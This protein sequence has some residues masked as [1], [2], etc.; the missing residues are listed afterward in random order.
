VPKGQ[1]CIPQLPF[2]THLLDDDLAMPHGVVQQFPQSVFVPEKKKEKR[3][4]KRFVETKRKRN[5]RT[6]RT[7]A[8]AID[9][10]AKTRNS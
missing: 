1:Q 3:K 5:H 10:T 2:A 9:S 6:V 7:H 8:I 4:R